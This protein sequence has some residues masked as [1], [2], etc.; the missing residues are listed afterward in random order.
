[1]AADAPPAPPPVGTPPAGTPPTNGS[2]Y[3]DWIKSDGTLNAESYSR[4]PEDIRYFGENLS[5]YKTPDELIRGFAN[6]S[7]MA[8][9]KGLIPLPANAPAEAVAQRK[10]LLDA[11][12]GVPKES[13]LYGLVKPEKLPD[14]V[15]WDDNRAGAFADWAFKHSVSPGAAKELFG[16]YMS[17][18]EGDANSQQAY[19]S[20]FYAKQSEEWVK[21]V[22]GQKIPADQADAMVERGAVALGLDAANP[23]HAGLLKNAAV[24]AACLK[25]ALAT[26]E[27]SYVSGQPTAGGS[28]GPEQELNDL[29]HNPSNP[30]YEPLHQSS[31]P[32]HR[33][34]VE[35]ADQLGRQVA[36]R[37]TQRR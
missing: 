24:R 9:G 25:H 10:A 17:Q 2:F 19:V 3:S 1:M 12:N 16:W 23:N 34:A 30:L 36:A 5:K 14:G 33:M 28:A 18:V 20:E 21:F 4:L 31:H 27:D 37:Q 6:M 15:T 11:A 32:Q 7:H 22:Q 13:K 8:S 35:K 26:S 29:I